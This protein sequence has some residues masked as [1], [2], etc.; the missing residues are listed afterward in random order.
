MTR[1]AAAS[2]RARDP[3]S[4]SQRPRPRPAQLG[5]STNF[6]LD[7]LWFL[8]HTTCGDAVYMV[9]NIY[10][11]C[12]CIVRFYLAGKEKAERAMQSLRIKKKKE[13]KERCGEGE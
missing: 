6:S 10:E 4:G 7:I 2:A 5:F 11:S 9:V 1:T 3:H 8:N 13:W 12:F